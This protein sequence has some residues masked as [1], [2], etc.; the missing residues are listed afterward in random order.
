LKKKI[1]PNI[2]RKLKE[3]SRREGFFRKNEE[4]VQESE[5][6]EKS[7]EKMFSQL[8]GVNDVKKKAMIQWME[9]RIKEAEE[10]QFVVPRIGLRH[11]ASM[12]EGL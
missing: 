11:H 1:D 10:K 4:E 2:E 9:M 8:K 5:E 12:N 6:Q 7:Q 3:R